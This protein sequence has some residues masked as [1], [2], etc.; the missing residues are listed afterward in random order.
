MT[1]L[2]ELIKRLS[3]ERGESDVMPEDFEAF[4]KDFVPNH[5]LKEDTFQKAMGVTEEEMR[6]IYREAYF[7]YQK[8]EYEKASHLFRALAILNPFR[9]EYW[10]GLGGSL[11]L[12][13]EFAKAVEAYGVLVHLSPEDPTP[14][15]HAYE[16]YQEL[17][18][19]DDAELA[20][21]EVERLSQPER[22]YAARS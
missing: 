8:E 3:E 17:G 22:P 18:N 7:H 16:C 6:A 15:Q 19:K 9:P 21:K 1:K 12:M 4:L 13:K 5:L 10:L 11:Q 14:H 20:L 2:D